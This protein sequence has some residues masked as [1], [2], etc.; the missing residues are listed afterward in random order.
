MAGSEWRH[1]CNGS[2]NKALLFLRGKGSRLT[3]PSAAPVALAQARVSLL[4]REGFGGWP[5]K[6][7]HGAQ[8]LPPCRAGRRIPE[9][10]C[11]AWRAFYA[12]SLGILSGQRDSGFSD[13][14]G[15]ARLNV[16][17]TDCSQSRCATC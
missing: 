10:P 9:M 3:L 16:L 14:R 2:G 1:C 17:G 11:G 15:L 8:A 5:V 12:V 7:S 6:G 13:G 4:L